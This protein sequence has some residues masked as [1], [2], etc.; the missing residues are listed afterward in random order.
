MG[1][2]TPSAP[3]V[4]SLV[5]PL[6]TLCS[7]QWLAES[8]HLCICQA[9]AEPLRRQLYQAPV[10]KLLLAYAIWAETKGMTIQRLPHLG[11]HPINNHQTQ[12]LL[13]KLYFK[14]GNLTEW[15]GRI[16]YVNC[17][18]CWFA[19]TRFL[20]GTFAIH[21]KERDTVLLCQWLNIFFSF[22]YLGVR[23]EDLE[24]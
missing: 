17:R 19:C 3:W 24:Q 14:V 22:R 8:I 6:G 1:L 2:Q 10:S 11:I 16:G 21:V 7:V 12:T 4:L 15:K 23:V 5:S 20:V 9:L 13:W 18:L